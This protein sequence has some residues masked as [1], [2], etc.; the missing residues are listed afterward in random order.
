MR[1]RSSGV[2][3]ALFSGTLA[4]GKEP[5]SNGRHSCCC[6]CRNSKTSKLQNL[7]HAWGTGLVS[8]GS[9]HP[10][11]GTESSSTVYATAAATAA[12]AEEH[13]RAAAWNSG[14][15]ICRNVT[16]CA[17]AADGLLLA[18]IHTIAVSGSGGENGT[19]YFLPL[20][21]Q[22]Q[23]QPQQQYVSNLMCTMKQESTYEHGSAL[24]H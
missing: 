4:K 21:Q 1:T 16:A 20:Q 19:V 18:R 12:A 5:C 24:M 2:C 7:K 23:N 13:G 17:R 11:Q 15:S 22:Q 9:L 10:V 8:H 6:C 14:A 3:P